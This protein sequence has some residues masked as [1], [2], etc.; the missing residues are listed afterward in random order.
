MRKNRDMHGY[1][2]VTSMG[3][4]M[5][6]VS[7]SKISDR[8][9]RMA[10]WAILLF[11]VLVRCIAFGSVPGGVNQDEAMAA[12]DGRALAQ[13]GTDRFG[14]RLPVHFAAWQVG[15]MSVLLSYCMVPFIKAAGAAGRLR[16][17][18][19]CLPG[20]QEAFG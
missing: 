12:V 4:E 10:F 18:G 19:G 17:C 7:G 9:R 11:A 15:Q 16:Q 6:G 2:A 20:W 13:Y 1:K 14:M 3:R 5:C 8:Q